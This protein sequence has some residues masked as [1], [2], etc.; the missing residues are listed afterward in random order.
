MKD[1]VVS[2]HQFRMKKQLAAAGN[3]LMSAEEIFLRKILFELMMMD[4][5]GTP[6]FDP[7]QMSFDFDDD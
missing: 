7:E 3:A 6:P 1:N 5:D 4:E 2:L